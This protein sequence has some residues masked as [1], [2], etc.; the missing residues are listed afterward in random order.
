MSFLVL[1]RDEIEQLLPMAE[2]IDAVTAALAAL[3]AGEMSMPLRAVFTPPGGNGGMAWMPAHRS[4]AEPIFGLKALC[5]IPSNPSARGL[6]AHQGQVILADGVTGQL[7]ALLDASVVT[8][9]R[10]AAVSA[11]ATHLLARDDAGVIAV[12]GTGVQARRH[13]EAIPLVRPVSE[14]RIAGRTPERAAQFVASFGG[15]FPFALVASG[16]AEDAVRGADVV[17][18]ATNSREPV[19]DRDWLGAGTHVNAIG[20]SQAVRREIDTRTVADSVL[21]TDRRESLEHEAGEYRLALEEGRI[22]PDHLRGELGQL[23]AGTVKGRSSDDELTLFRSLGLA[24]FDLAAAE[25][26]VTKALAA[27]VGT[28]VE[29]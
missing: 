7:R 8:A 12:I 14:A 25:H 24:V 26:V 3:D 29:F 19:L 4:G 6:D 21:F 11:V 17:V 9:I 20:A 2:C 1:K 28:T 5:V 18:T 15:D 27:G 22:G 16:S 10:T 23:V 13:L